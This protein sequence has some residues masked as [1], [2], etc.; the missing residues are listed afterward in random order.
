MANMKPNIQKA[1]RKPAG[2]REAALVSFLCVAINT[3]AAEDL[4]SLTLPEAVQSALANNRDLAATRIRIE[5]AQARFVQAGLWPNP[6]LEVN[7]RFDNTFNNEGE[8]NYAVAVTQPFSVSGRISAQKSIAQLVIE[9]TRDDVRAQ[10][11]LTAAAV[12]KKFT[13]LSA[14]REQVKLQTSLDGL[15]DQ[16][17]TAIQIAQTNGQASEKEVLS[18]RI[19]RQQTRQRLKQLE[20]EEQSRLLQ[21]I[22][23]TGSSLPCDFATEDYSATQPAPNLAAFTMERALRQRADYAAARLAGV[24]ASSRRE[25]SKSERYDDWRIGVGYEQEQSVVDGAPPQQA[26]QFVGVKLIVPLPLFDRKQGNIQ[27]ALATERRAVQTEEALR[28]Q[29]SQELADAR[30]RVQMLAPLLESYQSG[31]LER[32]RTDADRI[33]EGFKRGEI[34]ITELIQSRRQFSELTT[35]YIETLRDYRLAVIDLNCAMGNMEETKP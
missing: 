21:L 27:E 6:E 30:N 32:S 7:G 8:Y 1:H 4:P 13:E 11:C 33:E 9:Q 12:R 22:R 5:E 18:G 3:Q 15:N 28:L 17:L 14:L 34:S 23:L 20:I 31:L 2:L 25:L 29:I 10:E 35:S 16:L 26:G 19:A 24:L